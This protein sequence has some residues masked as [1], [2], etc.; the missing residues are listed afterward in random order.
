VIPIKGEKLTRVAYSSSSLYIAWTLTDG[1]LRIWNTKKDCIE[2][3]LSLKLSPGDAVISLTFSPSDDKLIAWTTQDGNWI[4]IRDWTTS[5]IQLISSQRYL[6]RIMS[7]AFSPNGEEIVAV[8]NRSNTVAV[9]D[10]TTLNL[11]R[12]SVTGLEYWAKLVA[13]SSD[14]SLIA[15]VSEYS[16]AIQ[17]W[18]A[19]KGSCEREM[20]VNI[21]DGNLKPLGSVM[22]VAF[23]PN[24][25]L[26]VSGSFKGT[27]SLWSMESWTISGE[28]Q[29]E[30]DVYSV[31]FS[32]DSKHIA[33]GFGSGMVIMLDTA[34]NVQRSFKPHSSPVTF[35]AFSWNSSQLVSASDTRICVL[36]AKVAG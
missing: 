14:S 2:L 7:I 18:D 29:F 15:S 16:T 19:K 8:S 25:K 30:D 24:G 35:I 4:H 12:G 36:D 13:F 6:N 28:K 3:E 26:L 27:I 9:H 17:I 5:G 34:W 21:R 20:Q 10:A 22:A 11:K 33:A 23:S 31:A 1:S 32:P